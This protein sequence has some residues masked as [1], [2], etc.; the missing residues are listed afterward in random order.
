MRLSTLSIDALTFSGKQRTVFD[1]QL[2]GFGIRVGTKA[3]TFVLMVGRERKLHSLGRY[4]ALSLKNAR[5]SALRL[6]ADRDSTKHEKPRTRVPEAI[7]AFMTEKRAQTRYETLRQYDRTLS[8]Y[9]KAIHHKYIEDV[10]TD[11]ITR[12]TDKLLKE[13][14][15]SSANHV[16][17]GAKTFLKWCVKR[18][19]ISHSP[20]DGLDRPAKE[21]TRERVLTDSELRTVWRAADVTE[22]SFGII[23]KLLLLT[24][25]RR[26]E[27]GS[28]QSQWITLNGEFQTKTLS[29][30]HD[31]KVQHLRQP[32]PL[33]QDG[34]NAT[35][36]QIREPTENRKLHG[37][38]CIPSTHTKNAREHRLPIGAFCV[39]LL[40]KAMRTPRPASGY[41]F[42]GKTPTFARFNSWSKPKADLDKLTQIASYCLH[43][44]R[45][46][47][48]T[49]L[50]RLGVRLEVIEALLNHRTGTRSG[51]VG[52]YQRH[53]YETEMREAVNSF[54]EWFAKVI[55]TE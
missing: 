55:L 1:D 8:I 4:P 12:V 23:V 20:A 7:E 28:L 43:D 25:Q 24:G 19:L 49:N 38:I 36:A 39:K 44:L 45:R 16:L 47:Y 29:L 21:V 41:I 33:R 6:L 52:I 15:G 35:W 27:I 13:N 17:V 9:L 51:V 3:K 30:G 53:R 14:K 11:D 42:L 50:Q 37:V 40:T 10:T 31:E 46:T 48:A 18:R 22:G 34:Q 5:Q 32:T 26:T 54:E 2:P